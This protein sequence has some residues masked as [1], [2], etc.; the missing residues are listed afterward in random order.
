MPFNIYVKA[1]RQIVDGLRNEVA[2]LGVARY[3]RRV[4]EHPKAAVSDVIKMTLGAHG[5]DIKENEIQVE[6]SGSEDFTVEVS[7]AS[8]SQVFDNVISNA[9]Y[10]LS[11]KSEIGDRKLAITVDPK[12]KSVVISNNGAV[13]AHN[14]KQA[15]FK[16]PFVTS[17]PDGRGLGMFICSEILKRNHGMIQFLPENDSRNTYG[18]ASF[19]IS[20]H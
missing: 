6:Y 9:I 18:S 17:K 2:F 13:I 1:I 11:V 19:M 10:W 4:E 3:V 8:L 16:G 20:F 15:L 7:A 12:N 14:I 5:E